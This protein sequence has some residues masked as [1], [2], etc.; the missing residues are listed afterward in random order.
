M[1]DLSF[2]AALLI[3]LAGSVHCV[4]MCG[5]IV[6]AL[7]FAIPT[8]KSVFPYAL[9]YNIGRISS[10]CIAGALT[11]FLGQITT[12]QSQIGL[13]ILQ[14]LSSL[15]LLMLA[16]YIGGWWQGLV[17]I[18]RLGKYLWRYLSP[19][20][21]KLIPFN[22]PLHALPYGMIWGWLPCGLVYSTL[23]WSL[24]SGDVWGGAKIMLGFG[25][26]TLPVMLLMALGIKQV[27]V[28]V[29]HSLFKQ[30]IAISL[31]L[32]ALVLLSKTIGLALF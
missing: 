32:Y 9:A 10:Y 30:V 15:F 12:Q 4:A 27:S 11:G 19:I 8:N 20:S 18:E 1:T 26:G 2:L 29:R 6:S 7:T 22:T 21:K 28:V 16:F 13:S 23:T 24:A 25:L 3:G 17:H 5:G 14:L 31:A